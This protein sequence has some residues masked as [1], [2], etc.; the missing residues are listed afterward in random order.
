[1]S[2]YD[3]LINKTIYNYENYIDPSISEK[4]YNTLKEELS[5]IQSILDK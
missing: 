1:M 4:L 2:K 3:K 5:K